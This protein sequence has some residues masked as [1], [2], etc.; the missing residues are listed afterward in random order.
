MEKHRHNQ[1]H[2]DSVRHI[3]SSGS[4]WI[5]L[6]MVIAMIILVIFIAIKE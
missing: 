6:A 2:W 3:R 4:G 5:V 1:S